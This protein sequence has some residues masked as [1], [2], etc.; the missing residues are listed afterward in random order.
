[1]KGVFAAP[2]V[3]LE[4]L[5]PLPSIVRFSACRTEAANR[6]AGANAADRQAFMRIPLVK[7][8][9]S[10]TGP[11]YRKCKTRRPVLPMVEVYGRPREIG[12][13]TASG[14]KPIIQ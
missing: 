4:M 1:M 14:K 7:C 11:N 8:G 13:S 5:L 2:R 12:G 3:G 6:I 9:A 10:G